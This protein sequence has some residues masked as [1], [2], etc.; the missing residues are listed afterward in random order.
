MAYVSRVSGWSATRRSLGPTATEIR[1][2]HM[3][4]QGSFGIELGG[5]CGKAVCFEE[6]G[7]EAVPQSFYCTFTALLRKSLITNGAGEG[8]RTLVIITNAKLR[9]NPMIQGRK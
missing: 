8:N 2:Q 7:D 1:G 9:A 6:E 5:K 4:I 3:L